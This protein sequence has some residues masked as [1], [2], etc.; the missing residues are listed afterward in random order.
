M[1]DLTAQTSAQAYVPGVFDDLTAGLGLR[2]SFAQNEEIYS[3]EEEAEFIYKV[4][5]GA[6]RTTR[7]LADGRRQIGDFYYPGEF[8]GLEPKEEHRFSAEALCDTVVLVIK[9]STIQSSGSSELQHEIWQATAQELTRAQD[10]L[11]LLGRKTACEKVASFLC[12]LAR[13]QSA[14]IVALP[15]GRQDMADFL[16]LTIETVSRMLTQLQKGRSVRFVDHRHFRIEN[17]DAI[18]CMCE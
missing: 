12:N 1:R 5:S 8:F 6:V 9:R 13:R 2:M 15:M 17:P 7:L 3:Q 18:A 11:L 10:H 4:I 16:G 14:E